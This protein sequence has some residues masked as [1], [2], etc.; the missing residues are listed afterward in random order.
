VWANRQLQTFMGK[1]P[2]P[3]SAQMCSFRSAGSYQ[4]TRSFRPVEC[5]AVGVCRCLRKVVRFQFFTAVTEDCP[6]SR[7]LGCDSL[8]I[9]RPDVSEER[10][11]SIIK[12]TLFSDLRTTLA[13]SSN[14]STLRSFTRATRRHV[15][16]D[17]VIHSHHRET[18]KSYIGL[19]DWAL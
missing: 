10:I 4:S 7:L 18:H 1:A 11:A 12:V 16:E 9:V 17:G 3:S 15:P 13:V 8:A 5:N 14:R 6:S 19:T 2:S